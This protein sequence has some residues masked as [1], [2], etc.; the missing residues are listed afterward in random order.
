[1]TPTVAEIV[2]RRYWLDVIVRL[3]GVALILLFLY[4]GI[5]HVMMAAAELAFAPLL[6]TPDFMF[7]IGQGAVGI[8]LLVVRRPL[9]RWLLPIPRPGCPECGYPLTAGKTR[10][11]ECG[12]PLPG[13]PPP[14][15]QPARPAA[16]KTAP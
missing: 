10:C 16:R 4:T 1:M 2:R 15:P 8:A 14:I 3:A 12:T 9:V 7:R 13:E 6:R 11:S 5:G